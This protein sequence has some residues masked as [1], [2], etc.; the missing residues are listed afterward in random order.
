MVAMSVKVNEGKRH[1]RM[2]GGYDVYIFGSG[3]QYLSIGPC[4]LFVL[5]QHLT[6]CSAR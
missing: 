4:E 6:A 1:E 2:Y 5:E 3:K